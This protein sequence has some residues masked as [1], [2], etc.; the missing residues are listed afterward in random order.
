MGR[1]SI[2]VERLYV[3]TDSEKLSNA[4]V[5]ILDKGGRSNTSADGFFD[6]ARRFL[7]IRPFPGESSEPMSISVILSR[8]SLGIM[9]MGSTMSM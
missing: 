2:K 8:M 9:L 6:S 5:R 4:D 3:Y 1:E 7:R